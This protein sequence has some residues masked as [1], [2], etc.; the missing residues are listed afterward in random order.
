MICMQRHTWHSSIGTRTGAFITSAAAAPENVYYT[1][2]LLSGSVGSLSRSY[3][4]LY[5]LNDYITYIL[6]FKILTFM[7][8][9][10]IVKNNL[11][12]KLLCNIVYQQKPTLVLNIP[13]QLQHNNSFFH[14]NV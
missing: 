1:T 11:C 7:Q 12:N 14:L 6:I 3:M 9:L 13:G 2:T 8:V 5:A 4:P 10:F